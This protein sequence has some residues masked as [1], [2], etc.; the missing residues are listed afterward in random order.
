MASCNTS[1]PGAS[2]QGLR[3]LPAEFPFG[4]GF[5]IGPEASPASHHA[6]S[7]PLLDLQSEDIGEQAAGEPKRA[8]PVV[9][10]EL[11]QKLQGTALEGSLREK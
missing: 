10:E 8:Y 4:C 2:A 7:A 1:T 3:H 5:S 9:S 6:C 11:G